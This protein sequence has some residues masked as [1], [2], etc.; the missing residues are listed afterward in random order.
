M[1]S[2]NDAFGARLQL[3]ID[4][5]L[6]GATT[7]KQALAELRREFRNEVAGLDNWRNSI[8]G[9]TA[10]INMLNASIKVEQTYQSNLE[11][12]IADLSK[13]EEEHSESLKKKQKEL[14][15][16][17]AEVDRYNKEIRNLDKTLEGLRAEEAKNNTALARLNRTINEQ[18][19]E[20]A[21]LIFSYRN[22]ILT[23]GKS[24][25]EARDFERRIK[26]L[27]DELR[28]NRNVMNEV[29]GVDPTKGFSFGAL[30][31]GTM[32]GNVAG[33]LLYDSLQ[34]VKRGFEKL[35]RTSIEFE[36]RFM[37][38]RKTVDGT[39]SDFNHLYQEL[40]GLGNELTSSLPDIAE[41][42][43]IAGQMGLAVDE[44][45]EFT[46]VMI[47]L[48][49][50]TNISAEEAG[51]S[52]AK[53]SNL[54]NLT[55]SDF[56][57]MGSAIV[58]LGNEFP[59][60]EADIA[61]MASRLSGMAGQVSMSAAD[62]LGLA[63]ALSAVG[64]EAEMG[65]NTISK[66]MREMLLSIENG[67][68]TLALFASTANMSVKEFSDLFRRDATQALIRFVEGLDDVGRNGASATQI[69]QKLNI[70]E[71][72]Q[73]DTLLRLTGNSDLLA[74]SINAAN[75]AW[76]DNT[77]LAA[78]AAK[79]Y[80]TT[81]SQIQFMK[82][83]W[84][85][86]SVALGEVFSPLI[87]SGANFLEDIALSIA[88]Q[89][90]A[91][92]GLTS[93]MNNL[94]AAIGEY[95]TAAENAEGATDNLTN[96]MVTLQGQMVRNAMQEMASDLG[97]SEKTLEG[98]QTT[99]E[100]Q[101]KKLT[102]YF[103]LLRNNPAFA[104]TM[105]SAGF[106]IDLTTVDGVL[107]A[108]EQL[109]DIKERA[110]IADREGTNA[111]KLYFNQLYDLLKAAEGDIQDYNTLLIET[112]T[113][114]DNLNRDIGTFLGQFADLYEAEKINVKDYEDVI[115]EA[116]A[117]ILKMVQEQLDAGDEWLDWF[118]DLGTE[119]DHTTESF[120]DIYDTL[121]EQREVLDPLSKDYWE[122][123]G[124]LRA[125]V[126]YCRE[127]GIEIDGLSDKMKVAFNPPKEASGESIY[128]MIDSYLQDDE[129]QSQINAMLGI[130][131]DEE[132]AQKNKNKGIETFLENA[133]IRKDEVEKTLEDNQ[134]E[135][136]ALLSQDIES[137]TEEEVKAWEEGVK[138][139]NDAIEN[140]KKEL[141]SIDLVNKAISAGYEAQ[142]TDT[143]NW[144]EKL[145]G[146]GTNE[147]AMEI[148]SGLQSLASELSS[149]WST[150]GRGIIDTMNT[151]WENQLEVINSQITELEEGLEKQLGLY[152]TIA[153][154]R[155]AQIQRMYNEGKISE[156][157][158]YRET[159]AAS[160]KAEAQK[161][162]AQ[163]E[164]ES[165]IDELNEKRNEIEKKQFE[166]EKANSI[167]QVLISAAQG[168]AAAWSRG[169]PIS[170]S[171]ISGLIA[172]MSAAQIAAIS[173]Q[174]YVPA[175]A[176]GG[177]V[178]KPT[179]ALIGEAGA[180]AVVPL[181]NNLGWI[182]E[183]ADRIS[184][185]MLLN[186]RV[187]QVRQLSIPA[188]EQAEGSHTQNF[189]QIINSPKALTRKEIYRQTRQLFR[190]A[191]RS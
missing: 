56:E 16:S 107:G 3:D 177:V 121:A 175:M 39:E 13:K 154:A 181:E 69:L 21:E 12:E 60:T 133:L 118:L 68:D 51:D 159:A 184:G 188:R 65:G 142:D 138:S 71:T 187:H 80:S 147:L 132:T 136:Q 126:E 64:L 95:E 91:S 19:N 176:T 67:S 41:I 92:R 112:G 31:S 144:Y 10:R 105:K 63:N 74:E 5:F 127:A 38:V 158:Y 11:K 160:S 123:E 103:I 186:E 155:E 14:E 114:T 28:E 79:R 57:R 24:S 44:V 146:V 183:L 52:L 99:L 46:R 49:D 83:A 130:E 113:R 59:T 4:D 140:G 100:K 178:T 36:S 93:S 169:E 96:A 78:E 7:A 15:N 167:A 108:Y 89:D 145:L 6:S 73:I 153:E 166:A 129:I 77:A 131:V 55:T 135:Y 48:G 111:E 170:A 149:L 97:E 53:L 109:E 180:E 90:N 72:R 27:N 191:G 32:L 75:E 179:T 9:V 40:Q 164:T 110:I 85:Q 102:D 189:T 94:K 86:A 172:A 120:N 150:L 33:N 106:D 157:E 182:N 122:I 190:I 50:T 58:E 152:D 34:L 61:T 23:F 162:E 45:G 82:N 26:S 168:I 88:G 70:T 139:Y 143:R 35:I 43:S 173:S 81:E 119:A 165:K 1:A 47:M 62:I 171:I 104:D 137:M 174:Q 98:Y 25:D 22:A 125:L 76:E 128:D 185:I 29:S 42:A 134:K 2:I 148:G 151:V 8:D 161:Q 141:E 101:G 66:T 163:E 124:R 115:G 156:E 116:S 17:R 20:L 87:R 18:E 37:D 117:T 30:F 84:Q 54:M